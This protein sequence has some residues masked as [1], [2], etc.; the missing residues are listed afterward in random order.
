LFKNR[1]K[2]YRC[3]RTKFTVVIVNSIEM[4]K[5]QKI[6]LYPKNRKFYLSFDL[7][8]GYFIAGNFQKASGKSENI[9]HLKPTLSY[10]F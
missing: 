8:M 5:K 10:K 4:V 9:P 1:S 2:Y 7:D 3:Y 6:N